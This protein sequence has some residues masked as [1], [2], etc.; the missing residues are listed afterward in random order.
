MTEVLKVTDLRKSFGEHEVLR[1]IDLTVNQG[2]TVVLLGSSGSG[3]STLLRCINFLEPP[4]SGRVY[5]RGKPVGTVKEGSHPPEISYR[6]RDLNE[7]RTHIGMVFQQFNLFPHL[8]VEQNIM[9]GPMKLRGLAKDAARERAHFQL[10][11]V[12]IADKATQYPA[13][14]SGGQ[15][16]RVAI[17]RALAME[18][19]VMLFDEATSA[20]DPE[21]VGEVLMVMRQ[22]SEERMTMIVVTHELGFAYNVASK[23]VFLH[24]GV[25]HEQGPPDQVL[26]APT[27]ERTRE[28][29]R[30]FH[31]FRI[32]DLKSEDPAAES[33]MVA[34]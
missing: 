12:G 25:I 8:T 11:R 7:L 23:V 24:Q 28:F 29:L 26:V 9:V 17:A 33:R 14:L 32:P 2:E 20:L 4:T 3:K 18:P 21:L 15:Q 22:L 5:F 13:R 31:L 16:Q 10:K 27:Q 19:D 34:N 30:G 1:G 6:A